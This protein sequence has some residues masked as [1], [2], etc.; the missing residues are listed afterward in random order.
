MS[1]KIERASS[2]N[3]PRKEISKQKLEDK[4]RYWDRKGREASV[5]KAKWRIR[6]AGRKVVEAGRA[7]SPWTW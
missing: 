7:Q 1:N 5:V 2:R 4:Q 3:S 6:W